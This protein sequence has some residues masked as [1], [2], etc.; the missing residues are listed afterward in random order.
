MPQDNPSPTPSLP[1]QE[2]RRIYTSFYNALRGRAWVSRGAML[3]P[4]ALILLFFT[5]IQNIGQLRSLGSALAAALGVH[6]DYYAGGFAAGRVD[7]LIW[8][9]SCGLVLFASATFNSA[10]NQAAPE[11]AEENRSMPVAVLL[12]VLSAVLVLSPLFAGGLDIWQPEVLLSIF[13]TSLLSVWASRLGSYYFSSLVICIVFFTVAAYYQLLP[14]GIVSTLAWSG[15]A[16]L[17]PSWRKDKWRVFRIFIVCLITVTVAAIGPIFANSL[18]AMQNP[19]HWTWNSGAL[20]LAVW[21]MLPAI[22]VTLTKIVHSRRAGRLINALTLGLFFIVF[23][24]ALVS[25]AVF[26]GLNTLCLFLAAILSVGNLL[27][28]SQGVWIRRT[29]VYVFVGFAV[30]SANNLTSTP[31]FSNYAA[32]K[33]ADP[34][35]PSTFYEYYV[36]WLAAR[37]ETA[38]DHGPLVLIAVAGGGVRAAAHASIALS[39][40]DDKTGGRFG[41]RTLMISAVSGGALGAATWLAQ[42]ADGLPPADPARIRSGGASPRALALSRFYRSDFLSPVVNRMLFHDLPLAALPILSGYSDRDVV[43]QETWQA[44]WESLLSETS[45]T[46]KNSSFFQREMVSLSNDGAFPLIVF[47]TTSA[48]DGRS[49]AYSS[50]PGAVRWSWQLDPRTTVARAVLDSARFAAISPVGMACAREG[51]YD[52]ARFSKTSLKC[53]PG[54]RPLAVADGGYRD[55][56]G[57]AEIAVVIDELARH[58]DPLDQVFVVQIT[59]NPDE[60]I[61]Q[62]QGTQFDN[63]RLLSEL[64]APAIVQESARS[65]HSEAYLHQIMGHHKQPHILTWGLP[66]QIVSEILSSQ[67]QDNRWKITWLDERANRANLERQLRLPPLGW[68]IDP[69]LYW[70]LYADSLMIPAMS[71]VSDCATMKPEHSTLCMALA[72]SKS[73]VLKPVQ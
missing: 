61:R 57:L 1:Q 39:L 48:A 29:A 41:E 59:S 4:T 14:L 25:P 40:A 38:A 69:V 5:L 21:W 68:T 45:N 23:L 24:I 7:L 3:W 10:K 8:W 52:I 66:H 30:M 22:F 44:T 15:F 26:F 11:I 67:P 58:G 55:N 51:A 33:A 49:A 65:G 62:L 35:N 27:R 46:P 16:S 37:G 34:G 12:H 50:Y 32:P 73:V 19:L 18:L 70:S 53:G 43:L 31:D 17:H 64:L 20:L 42:R 72:T 71:T 47:N 63:G 54:Y 28:T 56:S 13:T 9:L 36:K 2:K 6:D 60:G